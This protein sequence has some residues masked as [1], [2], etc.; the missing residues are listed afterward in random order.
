MIVDELKHCAVCDAPKPESFAALM[1][2]YEANYMRLRCL[3]PN[4]SD[5]EGDYA[6][7]HVAGHMDLHLR[8][9]DQ[10]RYTSTISLTYLF[11]EGGELHAKPDLVIR[12]YA[13]AR[14]AEVMS[15]RCQLLPRLPE[16]NEDTSLLCRWRSN[17]FLYKWLQYCL[18]QGHGFRT[19]DQSICKIPFAL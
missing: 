15:H 10:S 12:L 11:K 19:G 7:S 1:E 5:M 3:C 17:R 16:N 13:D 6:I 8:L 18:K 4:L 2:L 14:Q 9:L